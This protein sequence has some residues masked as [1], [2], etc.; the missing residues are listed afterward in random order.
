VPS[1]R[2][3]R[4]ITSEILVDSFSNSHI[5]HGHAVIVATVVPF[6]V[7]ATPRPI[8][9]R[10]PVEIR[11]RLYNFL[12]T[13]RVIKVEPRHPDRQC[14]D[15][16]WCMK[17]VRGLCAQL[18]RVCRQVHDEAHALLYAD[19]VFDCFQ[20]EGIKLLLKHIGPKNS[21]LIKHVII[22]RDQLQE[23]A[24]SLAKDEQK[25]ATSGLEVI[26]MATWRMRV[27]G[28]SSLLWRDVKSYER[29]ICQSA[30]EI[31]QKH[32]RLRV[33]AQRPFQKTARAAQSSTPYRIKWRLLPSETCLGPE[34][35]TVDLE[36]E[37]ALLTD[38]WPQE[39]RNERS[40]PT[41][42]DLI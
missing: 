39:G 10:V 12:L 35:D 31:C 16:D 40:R 3:H 9:L 2:L 4:L 6:A 41:G 26:E 32:P 13:G 37:L 24:W 28:G 38:G 17:P 1:F 42:L 8:L 34:E 7:M 36:K 11:L 14:D 18:L 19:N 30:L 27:L 5:G 22:D 33:V 21:A 23:F 29:Q 15:S 20:R 25:A